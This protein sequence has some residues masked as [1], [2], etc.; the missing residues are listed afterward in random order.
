MPIF[1]DFLKG[2]PN[3][4]AYDYSLYV[5]VPFPRFWIDSTRYDISGMAAEI[6]TLGF[7][8]GSWSDA[9]PTDSYYL[10]R[11]TNTCQPTSILGK[12]LFGGKSKLNPGYNM[13]FAY[14]YTHVNGVNEFFCRVRNKPS[15]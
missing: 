1:T 7:N 11:G 4:F 14:M 3:E 12:S 10:D 15:I 5:N 13:K 9:L 8:P 2:Q 6:A